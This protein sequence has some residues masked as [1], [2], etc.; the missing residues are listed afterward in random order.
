MKRLLPVIVLAT[1]F[2]SCKQATFKKTPGGMPYQVF[3]GSDTQTIHAG[4]VIKVS[5]TQKINDSVYFTNVGKPPFYIPVNGEIN[6]YDLSEIWTKIRVGDSIVTTQLMDTFIK[7]NPQGVGPQFKKGDRIQ[8]YVKVLGA[9]KDNKAAADNETTVK[10]EYQASEISFLENYL[11]GKNITAQKT[12]SGS[13]VEIINAGMGNAIDSGNYVSVYYTGTSF[14][15]VRFDSNTDTSFHHTEPLSFVVGTGQMILGFDEALKMLKNGG[16][17]KV[18]I[19]STLAYGANPQPGSKVKPY[20]H[21]IFDIAVS[22]VK[23]KQP[24]DL[25]NPQNMENSQPQQKK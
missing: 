7:R 4:D 2:T 11:K 25:P 14:S 22:D 5:F 8:T 13:F 21:L 18:Y 23:D 10:K 3:Q 9:F 12:P 20:E 1:L 19:P 24:A 17:A 16:V 6:P 15:G